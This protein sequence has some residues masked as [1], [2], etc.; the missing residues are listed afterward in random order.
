[1]PLIQKLSV[2]H[3]S[4]NLPPINNP[5]KLINSILK[6]AQ[7]LGKI[8]EKTAQDKWNISSTDN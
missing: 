5:E 8:C 2:P 4:G 6:I 7:Q 1:M 3:R